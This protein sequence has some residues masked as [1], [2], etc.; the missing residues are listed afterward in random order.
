[1]GDMWENVLISVTQAPRLMK[2]SASKLLTRGPKRRVQLSTH[3]LSTVV[4]TQ[5]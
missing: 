5:I 2:K 4:I 1:M 3:H